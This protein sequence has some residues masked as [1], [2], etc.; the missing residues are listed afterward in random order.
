[1]PYGALRHELA[2]A[3]AL[4]DLGDLM[5]PSLPQN[6]GSLLDAA[7]LTDASPRERSTCRAGPCSFATVGSCN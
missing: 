7:G 3:K 6:L 2:V 4:V 1:M 5:P